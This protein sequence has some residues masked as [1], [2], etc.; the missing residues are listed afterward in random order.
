MIFLQKVTLLKISAGKISKPAQGLGWRGL[1]L[2]NRGVFDKIPKGMNLLYLPHRQDQQTSA[3]IEL[4][5]I[6]K[7]KEKH[8]EVCAY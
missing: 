6:G 3:G 4:A 2:K 1:A 7:M 8:D 5:Q